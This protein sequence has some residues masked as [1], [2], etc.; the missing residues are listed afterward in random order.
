MT[1]LIDKKRNCKKIDAQRKIGRKLKSKQLPDIQC[2]TQI[3]N[4]ECA[5][6][7]GTQSGNIKNK[8]KYV[9]YSNKDIIVIVETS[10]NDKCQ[11]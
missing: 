10:M 1:Q 7:N 5:K 11:I 3:T 4:V 2:N 9:K 8:K 6:V